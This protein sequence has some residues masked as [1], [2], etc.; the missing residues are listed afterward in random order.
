M[1]LH[2]ITELYKKVVRRLYQHNLTISHHRHIQKL[3][4]RKQ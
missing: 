4:Q 1:T 3:R 2:K